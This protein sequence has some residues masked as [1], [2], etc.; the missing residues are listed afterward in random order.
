VDSGWNDLDDLLD[1]LDGESEPQGQITPQRESGGEYGPHR[2]GTP[3]ALAD[4]CSK[5]RSPV[6]I[7]TVYDQEGDE[8]RCPRCDPVK[9][10][11]VKAKWAIVILDGRV[12]R[13]AI[14]HLNGTRS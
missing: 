3:R 7:Q 6:M 10:T 13:R 8:L 2:K 1:A 4:P 12:W 11:F 9:K 5:C 14:E